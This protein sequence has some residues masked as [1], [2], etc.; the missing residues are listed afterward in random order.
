MDP[1]SLAELAK[2]TRVRELVALEVVAR[3]SRRIAM[4]EDEINA[5]RGRQVIPETVLDA[6]MV[7]KWNIWRREELGRL[8]QRKAKLI[9]EHRRALSDFGRVSGEHG[10]LNKLRAR[11]DAEKAKE[12]ESKGSYIS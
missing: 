2:L 12:A 10:V 6:A 3:V 8:N 1:R 7:E 5:L 4:I 11:A 9:V